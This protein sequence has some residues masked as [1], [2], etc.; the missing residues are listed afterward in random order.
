MVQAKIIRKICENVWKY[1]MRKRCFSVDRDDAVSEAF[2]R[3]LRYSHKWDAALGSENTYFSMVA[4]NAMAQLNE[5]ERRVADHWMA[6]SLDYR[7]ND[8]STV[9]DLTPSKESDCAIEKHESIDKMKQALAT[10]T[11][12]QRESVLAL[13]DRG[14][15]REIAERR[16]VTQQAVSSVAKKGMEKVARFICKN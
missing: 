2:E 15:Q 9:G 10:L 11:D 7:H 12:Y 13:V 14:S 4:R 8:G 6:R 5:R 16:G 3:C 1:E